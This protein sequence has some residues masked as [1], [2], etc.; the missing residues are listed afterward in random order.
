MRLFCYSVLY[1]LTGLI[2]TMLADTS[3]HSDTPSME[4]SKTT[5]G[6]KFSNISQPS[7]TQVHSAQTTTTTSAATSTTGS[8]TVEQANDDEQKSFVVIPIDRFSLE[9]N[10]E[11]E[12]ALQKYPG[13]RGLFAHRY[14]DEITSWRIQLTDSEVK[15]VQNLPG[16]KAVEKNRKCIRNRATPLKAVTSPVAKLT[17][18]KPKHKRHDPYT[19]QFN[20]PTELVAL[21]QPPSDDG[22]TNIDQFKNYIYETSAGENS[23]V[24]HLEDG[25]AYNAQPLLQEEF[26]KVQTLQ[27]PLAKYVLARPDVDIGNSHATCVADKA[28]GKNFGVAKEAT[29]IVVKMYA[30]EVDELVAG[31]RLIRDDIESHPERQGKSVVFSAVLVDVDFDLSLFNMDIEM[32]QYIQD[33]MNF[34]VPVVQSAGNL[35]DKGHPLVDSYPAVFEGPDFPM[36]IVGSTAPNGEISSFSQRGDHV[37]I[38]STGESVSCLD[39]NGIESRGSGTSLAAPI[40]ASQIAII[41]SHD[42][43]PFQ[44]QRGNLVKDLKEYLTSRYSSTIRGPGQERVLWN[45]VH[46]I[47]NPRFIK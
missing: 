13:N 16:V 28:V 38:Y 46:L 14:G 21:S 23:F 37:S 10:N 34:D 31:Y 5:L 29:L 41:L 12:N 45:G 2:A 24:Y 36:I 9:S 18:P 11:T 1:L 43:L 32:K 20:A 39:A 44:T 40:V 25:V 47:D 4:P 26:T 7:S 15:E 35:A 8:T 17:D 6:P 30:M 19:T 33:I 3:P 42:A 22:T 27:T